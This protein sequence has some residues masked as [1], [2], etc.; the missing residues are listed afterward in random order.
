MKVRN[1]ISIWALA[2]VASTNIT[3]PSLPWSMMEGT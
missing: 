1:A 3:S 2:L